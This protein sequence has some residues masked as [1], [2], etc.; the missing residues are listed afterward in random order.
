MLKEKAYVY[1]VVVAVGARPYN[2]YIW[3]H[4]NFFLEYYGGNHNFYV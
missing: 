1:V 2:F 3:V 4:L